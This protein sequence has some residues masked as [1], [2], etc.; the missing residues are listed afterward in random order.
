MAASLA[1]TKQ[2]REAF[3]AETHIGV[4]SIEEPG[5]GPLTLPMWYAYTPGGDVIL[6]TGDASKKAALLRAAGRASLL[7]QTETP[8]YRYISVE[9]PV[10][11]GGRPAVDE[12]RHMAHRYLGEQMGDMYLEMTA[13]EREGACQVRLTPERWITVDYNRMADQAGG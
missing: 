3:L 9:G 5:R 7:V 11:V 12:S 6:H 10:T 8:P 2:E 13:A 1:M 4:L